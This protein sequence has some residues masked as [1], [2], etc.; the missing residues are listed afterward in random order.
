MVKKNNFIHRAILMILFA[1]VILANSWNRAL[2]LTYSNDPYFQSGLEEN[3]KQLVRDGLYQ[4]YC[5]ADRE[6]ATDF[7]PQAYEERQ[8]S[9]QNAYVSLLRNRY[10][11]SRR[12]SSTEAYFGYV[13]PTE[14]NDSQYRTINNNFYSNITTL[15]QQCITKVRMLQAISNI[16]ENQPFTLRE[17]CSAFDCDAPSTSPGGL[18]T[19]CDLYETGVVL[20]DTVLDRVALLGYINE[21][22]DDQVVSA[23]CR[24]TMAS[25]A[26]YDS[27]EGQARDAIMALPF[28]SNKT[29]RIG[30]ILESVKLCQPC[31]FAQP[32]DECL[33]ENASSFGTCAALTWQP[34]LLRTFP[35]VLPN[36]L[37][38]AHSNSPT[39]NYQDPSHYA[40]Q[41]IASL[42]Q[43]RTDWET[44][45]SE[46]TAVIG[47]N[48]GLDI[49][50]PINRNY[51]GDSSS[52]WN[53]LAVLVNKTA[54][55]NSFNERYLDRENG[56][57]MRCSG[58]IQPSLASQRQVMSEIGGA[59]APVSAGPN[60]WYQCQTWK[61]NDSGSSWTSCGGSAG[62]SSSGVRSCVQCGVAQPRD[63]VTNACLHP[64]R[65]DW[66]RCTYA[67][68]KWWAITPS[69]YDAEKTELSIR[70]L[71]AQ[72]KTWAETEIA[73]KRL[74]K[75]VGLLDYT[76]GPQSGNLSVLGGQGAT[77][78][79]AIQGFLYPYM[80]EVWQKT[81][82]CRNLEDYYLG[83]CSGSVSINAT[84]GGNYL[85]GAVWS[86][87]ANGGSDPD[88]LK[89]KVCQEFGAAYKNAPECGGRQRIRC[90][91]D[92]A[93]EFA[94]QAIA[95]ARA[96]SGMNPN[97]IGCDKNSSCNYASEG[98]TRL[99]ICSSQYPN[100][101]IGV[102][103]FQMTGCHANSDVE[104]WKDVSNNIAGAIGYVKGRGWCPWSVY[105][106]GSYGWGCTTADNKSWLLP[107]RGNYNNNTQICLEDANGVV[108]YNSAG[109]CGQSGTVGG[110]GKC[111][112]R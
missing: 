111:T 27:K 24:R 2:A 87:D 71:Y 61:S 79:L 49:V 36:V 35:F 34:D 97:T 26:P 42:G 70:A 8:I 10:G 83:N 23:W 12:L 94:S 29:S 105:T 78:A 98:R 15:E 101:T 73:D 76:G 13:Q 89:D 30:Y 39:T 103:I 31:S 65:Q 88:G 112:H 6:R 16:C 81:A 67:D 28:Y 60:S 75:R 62:Y 66:A 69:G 18:N 64:E 84:P 40:Y 100:A 17:K 1:G 92:S 4:A 7:T 14:R 63:P 72:G 51:Y 56:G 43:Q 108:R 57:D 22:G 55:A 104:Y 99:S 85:S 91:A 95:I 48:A 20:G 80:S 82:S 33:Y 37:V 44:T 41:A 109:D 47:A 96:E 77:D 59:T 106:T 19:G 50:E 110:D 86:Y 21:L 54:A 38:N 32:T 107:G 45:N 90:V 58:L 25:A 46:K 9:F 102:G 5:A 11:E 74:T 93:A 68:I 53:T 3:V 52:I